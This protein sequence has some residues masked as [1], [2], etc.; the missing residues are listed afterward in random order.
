MRMGSKKY[1]C[2]FSPLK[3]GPLT[4]KNRIQAAPVSLAELSPGGYLTRENIAHYRLKAKGGA[5]VVTIGESIVH[6]PTGKSHPKQIPLDDRGVI[7]SLTEAADAI[8]Q[9]GALASIELSHGGMECDSVFLN[10]RNPIGPSARTIEIGFRTAE[11]RTVQVEEMSEALMDEVADAYADAAVTVRLAGFDMC[12][13]HAAHGWLL[14]Q[15]LSPLI[16]RRTDEYGGSLENRARFP[17]MVLDR[18]RDRVGRDFPIEFRMGGSELHEGGYT[19]ADAVALARLV[20]DKVDL[21]HVSCGAHYFVDT[22][23]IMH[24][25]M[26]LPHGCNVYLAEAVKSAVDIPVVTVGGLSDPEQM[27]EIIATG[28][29]DVVAIARG[30]LAD[31]DLPKKAQL[32]RDDEII[33]CLRC[34]ECQSGMFTNAVTK[35]SVNPIIG[36]EFEA[37]LGV[38][39]AEPKKVLVVGGGP[40][41]MQA[42]ITAAERGHDVT[43]FEKSGSLGGAL[44]HAEHVSFKQ[45]LDRFKGYLERRLAFLPID[46]LCN[47]EVTPELVESERPDVLIVSV[48]A[49]PIVPEIAGVGR[50]SVLL[51]AEAHGPETVIGRRVVVIG[52]GQV[53]CETG[54]HLAQQGKEVTIVEMLDEVAPDANI[55]HRRAL[56]PELHKALSISTGLKAV[57]ITDAGVVVADSAGQRMTLPC[58]S[59]IIAVGYRP[60]TGL[61]DSLRDCAPEVMTVGDC[62]KPRRLLQ[63]VR[64]GYDAGMAV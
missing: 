38:P 54:L 10:G 49:E 24:P 64:S 42:A 12:M 11:A 4:L 13:V 6:T 18:I 61:V 40:A 29:A 35:C 20:E 33:H 19:I 2:L 41:G 58:D 14:A 48:G 26:F 21:L 52:G 55:M 25:S 45:D 28:R 37:G 50:G 1:P 32:G 34:F 30:L 15:F 47:T 39:P 27:E 62:V 57:E 23:T 53:G 56:L 51:A 60:R 63:A 16:N 22:M 17:L 43:L 8:H 31:P 7:A 46:V 44:K 36:R 9:Y 5:A 59:V 3:I